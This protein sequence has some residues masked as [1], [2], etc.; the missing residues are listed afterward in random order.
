MSMQWIRGHPG[1]RHEFCSAGFQS[2]RI[3]GLTGIIEERERQ[4][5]RFREQYE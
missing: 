2:K 4:S 5:Q 1:L 3:N